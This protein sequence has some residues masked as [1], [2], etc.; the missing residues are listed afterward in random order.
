MAN[1]IKDLIQQGYVVVCDTNVYLH[2]YRYSPEFSDFAL[3]CMKCVLPSIIVPSTVKLEFLKHY[4]AYFGGMEKRVHNIANDAKSQIQTATQKALKICDNLQALQYPD[5][6]TLRN[7]LVE[8]FGELT[9]ITDNFFEDRAI[10]DLIANPWGGE[11][12][13]YGMF[14]QIINT[15]HLMPAITQEEL[16]LFCEEGEKRYNAEPPIPPGF[17]DAKSKD[18]VRKYSDF[19]IW[20][21]IIRF[22]KSNTANVIF[23]TDDAKSD[24]WIEIE[25][26]RKFHPSLV[27]E[28]E[29]EVG[30]NILSFVA[31]DFFN[32]VAQS[33][34]VAKSDAIE[35]AL[36]MTDDDY[37]TRTNEA[38]FCEIEDSLSLSG[39][40]YIEPSAHLSTSGIGEIEIDEW[41]FLSAA[42]T[43][44]DQER[45]TYV[46][47][48][49]VLAKATS[50]EYWAKDEYTK[51]ILLCPSGSHT[52][53]GII[54]VEVQREA[55]MYLDFS[56]DN[57][58]ENVKIIEGHLVETDYQPIF[59][60]EE[61][62]PDAF[63]ICPDCGCQINL[64]NDGGNGFCVKCAPNH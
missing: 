54:S 63:N 7:S 37:F 39:E 50:F 56:G 32:S 35:I 62:L 10:L 26:K 13:V 5:I 33:Y 19:I 38:V 49:N 52:F 36:R 60:Y 43:G 58:F 45:I 53:E 64:N 55:D 12:L 25:G 9:A 59:D 17:K 28:F 31:L 44:R 57:G 47:K 48:Y 22:A 4:R 18:G 42:Q 2:I 15:N 1:N 14:E 46:F 23:V 20:K 8:K 27:A 6:S 16:Y 3:Q 41:E 34:S 30:T 51:E 40:K 61:P 11:D 29:N 21:E 24:W